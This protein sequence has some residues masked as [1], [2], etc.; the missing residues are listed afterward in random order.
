MKLAV[1]VMIAAVA[2]PLSAQTSGKAEVFSTK[3]MQAK[4]AGL[5]APLKSSGSG[6]ALLADYKTHSLR[7]VTRTTSGGAEVHQH[8]DDVIVVTEGTATLITGGTLVDPHTESE[9]EIRGSSIRDGQSQTI[10]VGDV[11]HVPA[12]I[13]HQMQVPAGT[14]YS[15]LVVKVKE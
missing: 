6:T 14:T 13:P 2:L 5:A 11:V 1:F 10:S 4:L 12:G 9:G 8:L 3:D 7:L 15:G